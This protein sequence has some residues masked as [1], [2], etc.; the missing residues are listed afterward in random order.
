MRWVLLYLYNMK[1]ILEVLSNYIEEARFSDIITSVSGEDESMVNRFEFEKNRKFTENR[2][3]PTQT[4]LKKRYNNKK[5]KV[6]FEWNHN[7][8]HNLISRIGNRTNLK[9][10]KEFTE[11]FIG[12]MNTILPDYIGYLINGNDTYAVYLEEDNISIIF[13]INLNGL[14]NNSNVINVDV[15]TVLTGLPGDR[16]RI[17]DIFQV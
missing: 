11:L 15:K 14:L 5:V 9:S 16:K 4:T 10:V 8:K 13:Y 3:L 12:A 6:W 2:A 7:I 1:S 17:R